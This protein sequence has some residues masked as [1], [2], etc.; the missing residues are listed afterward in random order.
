MSKQPEYMGIGWG[1][2]NHFG[3]FAQGYEVNLSAL[4]ESVGGGRWLELP[5]PLLQRLPWKST[6]SLSYPCG[7]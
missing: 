3:A 2:L 4:L 7:N 6:F 5:V 1:S